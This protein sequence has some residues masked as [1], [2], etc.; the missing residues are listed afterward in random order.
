MILKILKFEFNNL[1]GSKKTI[2]ILIFL[3]VCI[4]VTHIMFFLISNYSTNIDNLIESSKYWYN[5]FESINNEFITNTVYYI[6]IMKIIPFVFI[7]ISSAFPIILGINSIIEEKE[8]NTIETLFFLPYSHNKILF[9]KLLSFYTITIILTIINTGIQLALI[10]TFQ[11]SYEVMIFWT[12]LG[13]IFLPIWLLFISSII[14]IL[15]SIYE[16]SKDVNQSSLFVAFMLY[17]LFMLS[18]F[19]GIDILSMKILLIIAVLSLAG[20]LII[21]F[22]YFK[23]NKFIENIIYN[24]NK[25]NLHKNNA[26]SINNID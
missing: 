7:L 24:V 3:S 18:Y 10:F 12:F 15:S 22:I 14:L 19:T 26:E 17:M 11:T 6:G 16:T 20:T 2:A 1:R 9:S 21:W 23:R 5:Q 25:K 4:V 13:L 8:Q